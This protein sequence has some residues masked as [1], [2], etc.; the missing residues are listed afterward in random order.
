MDAGLPVVELGNADLANKLRDAFDIAR[1]FNLDLATTI[2]PVVSVDI[3][4]ADDALAGG[5]LSSYRGGMTGA[6]AVIGIVNRG[7][8]AVTITRIAALCNGTGGCWILRN[9]V[10][11]FSYAAI[12]SQTLGY[13]PLAR[14][15]GPDVNGI[16]GIQGNAQMP[17]GWNAM[18]Q[19]NQALYQPNIQL[20][21]PGSGWILESG[22]NLVIA[23]DT[24]YNLFAQF[25]FA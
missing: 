2:V 6:S 5:I 21:V 18:N 12:G 16:N 24:T 15:G 8:D 9:L 3:S 1:R 13:V 14:D 20:E 23:A 22:E 25:E 10:L 11:N 4:A 17:A 7:L 19:T